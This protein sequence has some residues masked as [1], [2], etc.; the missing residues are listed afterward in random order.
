MSCLNEANE[1][2][3]AWLY[4]SEFTMRQCEV[5]MNNKKH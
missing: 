4:D 5:Q 3:V 1:A 2:A